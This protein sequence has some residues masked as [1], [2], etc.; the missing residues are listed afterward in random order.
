[1]KICFSHDWQRING[2]ERIYECG[3]SKNADYECTKCGKKKTFDICRRKKNKYVF[4]EFSKGQ[5]SDGYH[6]FDELYYHRMALFSVICNTYKDNAWKSWKHHDGT[7]YDDY[8]I[9]GITTPKGDYTYHYHKDNWDMFKVKEIPSA[10]EWDGHTP[11]DI[12]RL[13][14]LVY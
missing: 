10:P 1:M 9:V 12:H 4:R 6:T 13:F 11:S 3:M 5:I 8:F 14:D 7:M 2:T